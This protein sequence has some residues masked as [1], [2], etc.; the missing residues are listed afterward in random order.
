MADHVEMYL[1]EVTPANELKGF[2]K[3]FKKRSRE[4]KEEDKDVKDLLAFAKEKR[5]V[6]GAKSAEKL[7]KNAKVEKVFVAT[8]SDE[9]SLE[10]IEHYGKISNVEIIK[11]SIDKDELSQKLGKPFQIS[12]VSILKIEVKK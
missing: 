4:K 5:L 8:N 7:F 9:F 1:Q 11:L 10:K 3:D 2:T 6:F 12:V